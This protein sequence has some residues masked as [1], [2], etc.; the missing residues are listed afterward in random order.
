MRDHQDELNNPE[1]WRWKISKIFHKLFQSCLQ[2]N[3]RTLPTRKKSS[4]P[5]S[6]SEKCEIDNNNW[7]SASASHVPPPTMIHCRVPAH[8]SMKKFPFK[9]IELERCESIFILPP[10]SGGAN[11]KSSAAFIGSDFS[12]FYI[13]SISLPRLFLLRW[14]ESK[15]NI[16]M[17]D[18]IPN[19]MCRANGWKAEHVAHTRMSMEWLM[20][21]KEE[22]KVYCPIG[23]PEMENMPRTFSTTHLVE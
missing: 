14:L 6:E 9:T 22:K 1:N 11:G 15:A 10:T 23:S 12:S 20:R 5:S 17:L 2:E 16:N 13:F 18:G 8:F 19:G 3:E 7:A 21:R 4:L